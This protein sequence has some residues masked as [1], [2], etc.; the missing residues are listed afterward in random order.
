MGNATAGDIDVNTFTWSDPLTLI[1]ANITVDGL[2]AGSNAVTLESSTG[3]I[4][5]EEGS[6]P[7]Y[8]NFHTHHQW[9]P[10][11][12]RNRSIAENSSRK[13]N[14]ESSDT[15]TVNLDGATTAGTDYDQLQ[16]TGTPT[17]TLGGANFS[18]SVGGAY[19]PANGDELTIIDVAGS[20]AVSGT[21]IGLAEGTIATIDG[22]D[23]TISYAGGDGNDITLTA[24]T[25]ENTWTGTATG[26]WDI[27]GNWSLNTIP[28]SLH[29]V[30]IPVN[31][32][33]T[34]NGM[35]SA[36]MV[37]MNSGSSLIAQNNTN[38]VNLTYN[39]TLPTSN[40]YL[41]AAPVSN[42]DIDVFAGNES[43][44]IGTGDNQGLG[45]YNTATDTWSYYQSGAS[46]SGV[47]TP[48]TG[49]AVNLQNSD[50][51]I[52]FSGGMNLSDVSLSLTT[53]G[54]GFNL[55]GN[56]YPSYLPGNIG[57]GSGT[58]LIQSNTGILEENTMWLWNQ[59][60]DSYDIINYTSG[61]L[62]LAPGQG[63]FVQSGSTGGTFSIPRIDAKSS[64]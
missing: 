30:N 63:F 20:N 5:R 51:A 24:S 44:E 27:A 45:F 34:A 23:F 8:N 56:P 13:Y 25:S 2:N 3:N 52:A 11:A 54:N 10:I 36:N 28:T 53:T 6:A 43:L 59:S 21:F 35:M 62:Y 58:N 55:L 46:G 61:D 7:S 17:L 50:D 31:I 48:G 64:D 47:F 40:W 57:G 32:S 1:G 4:I 15:F 14:I 37:T 22:F 60:T 33:V 29:N 38:P 9:R 42:Q 18:A 19:S 41:V 26:D 39:R 49:A 16:L 12:G